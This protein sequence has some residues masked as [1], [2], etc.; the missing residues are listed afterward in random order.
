MPIPILRG[1]IVEGPRQDPRPHYPLTWGAQKPKHQHQIE[2]QEIDDSLMGP[3]KG[4]RG[5]RIV[6]SQ[7][8]AIQFGRHPSN[9]VGTHIH[10]LK[11]CCYITLR[12]EHV[13]PGKT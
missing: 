9:I 12:Q 5:P 1:V 13:E 7:R 6:L 3:N 10:Q 4:L 8:H 2:R 11:R